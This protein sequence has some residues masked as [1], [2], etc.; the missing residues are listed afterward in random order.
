MAPGWV[1]TTS[2]PAAARA[3]ASWKAAILVIVYGSELGS[4]ITGASSRS[5]PPAVSKKVPVLT[6]TTRRM[7]SAS[8]ASST[9]FVPSDVHGLEVGQVLAGPAEER[10]AVD[11]GVGAGGGPT[12]VVGIGD[13]AGARSRPR[14]RPAARCRLPGEPGPGRGRPAR[15]GA[16]RCWRRPARWRR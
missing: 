5:R 3:M 15:S 12:D 7:P 13:V 9:C 14:G 11:G 8:A 10:G 16:C 6:A 4:F 2:W 1:V